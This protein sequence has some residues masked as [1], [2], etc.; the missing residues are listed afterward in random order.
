MPF[1]KEEAAKQRG[2]PTQPK[3][4]TQHETDVLRVRVGLRGVEAEKNSGPPF[5]VVDNVVGIVY[6]ADGVQ[7]QNSAGHFTHITW[8]SVVFMVSEKMDV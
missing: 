2:R 4:I 1:T 6:T 7:I 8:D 5:I 3:L